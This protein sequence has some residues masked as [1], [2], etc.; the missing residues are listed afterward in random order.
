MS[1]FVLPE[2]IIPAGYWLGRLSGVVLIIGGI[3]TLL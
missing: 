3:T 2:K 1:L